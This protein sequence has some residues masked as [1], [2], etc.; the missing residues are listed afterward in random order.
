MNEKEKLFDAIVNETHNV[1]DTLQVIDGSIHL[2]NKLRT[3]TLAHMDKYAL[4]KLEVLK[5][6]EEE[7]GQEESTN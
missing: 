7:Y 2:L 4:L 3:K 6:G 5:M 1:K